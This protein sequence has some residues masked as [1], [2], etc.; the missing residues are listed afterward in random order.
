MAEDIKPINLDSDQQTNSNPSVTI[1][2]PINQGKR[3]MIAT[4]LVLVLLGVGSG[5]ALS[6]LKPGVATPK[7][8]QSTD[9]GI[10]VGGTYGIEDE[11]AFKDAAEG[12]MIKGG[13]DGEG[14]HHLERE[15]GES[16][17][18]Y[19]TSSIIDLDQFV[20]KSVKVWGDT[21]SAQQAGWLMDIGRLQV[22]E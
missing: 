3:K 19:L 15:G 18:V 6:K 12:K 21:F 22:L 20:G 7:K 16:Q 11:K 1:S 9:E 14:S 10:M 8:L 13:I 4:F 17:Y 5:F 2:K